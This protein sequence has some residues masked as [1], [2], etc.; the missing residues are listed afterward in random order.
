LDS[1][2]Q[3]F[4]YADLPP[5]AKNLVNQQVAALKGFL[6]TRSKTAFEVLP[7]E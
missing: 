5:L 2:L 4:A 1:L 6:L 7:E 3:Q